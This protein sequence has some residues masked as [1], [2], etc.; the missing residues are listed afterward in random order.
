LPRLEATGKL[1]NVYA[2]SAMAYRAS[3]LFAGNSDTP[4]RLTSSGLKLKLSTS[5]DL[6]RNTRQAGRFL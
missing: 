1:S 2:S 6:S 3:N 4:M 5:L